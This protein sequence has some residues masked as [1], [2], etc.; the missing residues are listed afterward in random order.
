[1]AGCG[2]A[3]SS[4][5]NALKCRCCGVVRSVSA[6]RRLPVACRRYEPLRKQTPFE[7]SFRQRRARTLRAVVAREPA[8]DNEALASLAADGL[9]SM[10]AGRVSLPETGDS[11]AAT[12]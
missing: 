9:V 7:G 6:G 11:P 8:D 1:M 3:P 5:T 4:R 10:S 2:N 12:A